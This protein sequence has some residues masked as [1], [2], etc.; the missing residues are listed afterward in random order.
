MWIVSYKGGFRLNV[1][2]IWSSELL[3]SDALEDGCTYFD[4]KN[5]S[6]AYQSFHL[7]RLYSYLL[8]FVN[9]LFLSHLSLSSLCLILRTFFRL[10]PLE[11]STSSTTPFL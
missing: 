1:D 11:F 10:F 2:Q 7:M 4:N 6:S 8:R 9:L 5:N 3:H